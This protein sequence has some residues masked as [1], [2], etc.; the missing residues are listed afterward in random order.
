MND[1]AAVEKY[2]ENVDLGEVVRDG[3]RIGL[4]F[5]RHYPH[6]LERVW[7]AITESE[8]IRQWMPCDLIG[9]RRAG[10]ELRLPFDAAAVDKYDIAEPVLTGRI[11]IWQPPTLFQWTWDADVLR[12]ELSATTT[13][14]QLVFT[15]W[16]DD[17][18]LEAAANSAG[19]YHL[20]LAELGALLDGTRVPPL[21]Q[22]DTIAF[23][24]EAAYRKRLGVPA[25]QP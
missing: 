23:R 21:T 12:F 5:V 1:A 17:Q 14:T 9:E 2:A 6:P 3:D 4:Q 7:R 20:C 8:D 24:F 19:G 10:A 15:T 13:G 22:L 16:P 25:R 18:A 11:E